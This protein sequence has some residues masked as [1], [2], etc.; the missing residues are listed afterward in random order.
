MR[1]FAATKNPEKLREMRQIFAG[2]PVVLETF[3]DYADVDETADSYEGN[4]LLK[5]RALA[6]QL[7]ERGIRA[8]ALS[9][10]SGLEVDA[11]DGRPGVYSARYAGAEAPWPARRAKLLDEMRGVAAERRG[12]RFVCV[13]A[14][15]AP[16]GRETVARGTVEGRIVT[17]ECGDRGFGYDPVFYFPPEDRTFAQLSEEAKNAVSHRGR[18]GKAL[19]TAIRTRE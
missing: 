17:Q 2:S 5:A 19:L 1:V 9:D 12:A 13:M 3:D 18:A 8:A 14:F 10:D 4:A 15:V 11:L 7:R 16:D 6:A